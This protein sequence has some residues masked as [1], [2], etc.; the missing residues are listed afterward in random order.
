MRRIAA[1]LEA[2]FADI[3]ETEPETVAQHYTLAGLAAE[4]VPWW[5]KAGQRAMTRSANREAAAHFAKGLELVASLP[6]SETRLRQELSLRT[7]MGSALIPA[8]G[9]G[10][11]EV[12]HAFST[13]RELAERLGDKAQ[14]FAAVRGES[15][16]RTISGHLRAAE[17]LALQC[18]T[19]GMELAQA[20][21]DSAYMLE[22]HHQLWGV[23][24]YLGD[25]ETSE[26]TCRTRAWPPT[27]TSGIVTLPG[28]IPG[29]TQ[30]SAAGRSRHRCS[31][32]AASRTAR[33][34]VARS[35]RAWP[36]ATRIPFSRGPGAVGASAS[37]TSC[38]A[39]PLR[40]DAGRKRQSRYAP[41]SS[42]RCCLGRLVSSSAGRLPVWGSW[43]RAS[44]RCGRGSRRSPGPARTWEWPTTSAPWPVPAASAATQ[45]KGLPLLERAFDTLAKSGSN[46][47]LPELLRTKGELLSRWTQ[48]TKPPKAGSSNR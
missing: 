10:D 15:A 9:W 37:S 40:D 44:A 23:N 33:S 6:A 45:A 35:D 21:G 19:L 22:A 36:S 5:L 43:T 30:A 25:Y 18:Q 4:A 7:A 27:I 42:C 3:A 24:F 31:A 39:S 2:E 38:D 32:Y 29:T 11:P 12:L 8:K 48:P 26:R 16:C 47:Q 13:A 1:A 20:S 46:Y 34:S 28:A 14:L 41:S 17:T